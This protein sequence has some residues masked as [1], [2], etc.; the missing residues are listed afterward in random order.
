MKTIKILLLLFF[1]SGMV[2]SGCDCGDGDNGTKEI[3]QT[4]KLTV[5]SAHGTPSPSTSSYRGIAD[6]RAAVAASVDGE[7]GIRYICTGWTGTGSVPETGDTNEVQFTIKE[8]SS[9][10][11][12]WRTE[13]LLTVSVS[14]IGAGEI[15]KSSDSQWFEENTTVELTV[16]PQEGFTFTSWIGD[17]TGNTNPEQIIMDAPKSVTARFSGSF[18]LYSLF[19]S[20]DYAASL[21][22]PAGLSS[23]IGGRTVTARADAVIDIG[24]GRGYLC[25]GWTGTGSVPETGNTNEAIF[26][27]ETDSSITWHWVDCY[28]LETSILPRNSG[29]IVKDTDSEWYA[30]DT[31]V[32]LTATADTG[33][34]FIGWTGSVSSSDTSITV[35]MDSFKSITADFRGTSGTYYT[36]TV[37]ST[38]GNPWPPV[39]TH[40]ITPDDE[41]AAYVVSPVEVGTTRYGCTRF[42]GTGSVPASGTTNYTTF[43]M[44]RSST[45][46]WYWSL[47]S[48]RL[49]TTVDPPNSGTVSRI[50]NSLWYSPNT[51][52]TLTAVPSGGANFTTWSGDVTNTNTTIEINMNG[53]K[54]LIANFVIINIRTWVQRAP[55][56]GNIQTPPGMYDFDMTYDSDREVVVMFGGNAIAG[57]SNDTW[58]WNGTRWRLR[59]DIADKPSAR[60]SH[61]MAY[62]S[63]RHC[64]VLFGGNDNS[65]D[66]YL[67]DTW[68]YNGTTWTQITTTRRPPGRRW[69]AMAYDATRQEIIM[70]G[71]SQSQ[72]SPRTNDTWSYNGADWQQENPGV[73]PGPRFQHAMAYDSNRNTVV[74][75]GGETGVPWGG[76]NS[77]TWEWDG[78]SW[79][80]QTSNGPSTATTSF[81]FDSRRNVSVLFGG[82]TGDWQGHRVNNTWFWNGTTWTQIFP[83]HPPEA[84]TAHKMAYDAAREVCVLFGGSGT[85]SFPNDTLVWDGTDWRSSNTNPNPT[86]GCTLTF[87]SN[88]SV[89]VLFGG[90]S[91]TTTITA[92]NATWEWNGT[93]WRQPNIVSLPSERKNHAAVFDAAR[94]VTL[95]FGGANSSL[96]SLDE[97]WTWNGETWTQLSP[98]TKPSKREYLSMAYDS[99]REIVVMFGG[100]DSSAGEYK[101]DTWEWDGTNW[102]AQSPANNPSAR[103]YHSMTY[104]SEHNK[105][106]MF[107]GYDDISGDKNDTWEWDGTNWTRIFTENSPDARSSA[108]VVYTTEG[109]T[110]LF[111]GSGSTYLGDT[112]QYDGTDWQ[113]VTTTSN[114]SPRQLHA[115]CYNPNR[116]VV[117]LF[118]GFDGEY[119]NDTWE[120]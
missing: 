59:D 119:K 98:S 68:E 72:Q 96:D 15:S 108:S 106:I 43:R 95:I 66:T 28:K 7:T 54:T 32:Q 84:R 42:S 58:E 24:T 5:S 60:D 100:F 70:F 12:N 51:T 75:H 104:D 91:E 80:I 103:A 46:T 35:A 8:D 18:T 89:S 81:A 57:L 56:G 78:S 105:V 3:V 40:Y 65:E 36:L 27:I 77:E 52:V 39:G 50:P 53:P 33:F 62:D 76:T 79:R 19:V 114:P 21:D 17:L 71:G 97:T 34:N 16:V 117:V 55:T 26:T 63:D 83:L 85:T 41:I 13:Y 6:I 82:W 49:T 116:D 48:Y 112:W 64:I 87:D 102:T 37:N 61:C 74:L 92:T 69:S 90:E 99:D 20:S 67:Y 11:W 29:T 88:R 14:P 73:R 111:G 25:T 101:N 109:I 110:F 1:I 9:L 86:S 47:D 115:M 107:G 10:T 23:C 44:E 30:E 118:G 2:F 93:I 4:Y 31:V 113:Q 120:Y 45:I 22:P 94:G 38:R